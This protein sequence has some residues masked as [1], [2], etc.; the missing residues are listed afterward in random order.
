MIELENHELFLCSDEQPAK[1]IY[2]VNMNKR[3]GVRLKNI[4]GRYF[5]SPPYE[6]LAAA[7]AS[8]RL[9]FWQPWDQAFKKITH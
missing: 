9:V 4:H 5:L 6:D 3:K 7:V 2:K 1:L 8:H